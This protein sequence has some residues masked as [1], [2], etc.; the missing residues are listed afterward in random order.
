[1]QTVATIPF[2][3]EDAIKKRDQ[4]KGH[5]FHIGYL[6]GK[7]HCAPVLPKPKFEIIFG[8]YRNMTLNLGLTP[9]QWNRLQNRIIN[10]YRQ[11]GLL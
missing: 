10:F 3:V 2:D 1:M 6:D 4:S 5:S 11:K 9:I 8:A 7:I